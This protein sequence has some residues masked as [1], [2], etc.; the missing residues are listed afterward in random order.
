MPPARIQYNCHI[1]GGPIMDEEWVESI[2]IS[3]A[4]CNPLNFHLKCF[5]DA[6]G[7]EFIPKI[8]NVTNPPFGESILGKYLKDDWQISPADL[9]GDQFQFGSGSYTLEK[10]QMPSSG[11]LGTYTSKTGMI[12]DDWYRENKTKTKK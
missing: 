7:D 3:K 12:I 9:W 4:L 6:A 2:T 10:A 5:H 11:E 8:V 1:C